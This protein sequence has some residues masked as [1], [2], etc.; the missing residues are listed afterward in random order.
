[1][2][3]GMPVACDGDPM[4]TLLLVFYDMRSWGSEVDCEKAIFYMWV[5]TVNLEEKILTGSE[6]AHWCKYLGL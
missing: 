6:P 5:D 3:Q 1:M 2:E 4:P